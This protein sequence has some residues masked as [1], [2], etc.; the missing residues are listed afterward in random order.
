MHIYDVGKSVEGKARSKRTWPRIHS[1]AT[2]IPSRG[3]RR[4]D[5]VGR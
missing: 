1:A 4:R 2:A 3:F 5:E